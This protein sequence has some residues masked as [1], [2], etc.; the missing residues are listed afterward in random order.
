MKN[1]FQ[2]ETVN[3]V[4]SMIDELQATSRRQ[5]GNGGGRT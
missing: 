3:E 1:L 2:R 4:I 5:W